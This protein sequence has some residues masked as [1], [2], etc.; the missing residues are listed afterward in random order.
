MV[1]CEKRMDQTKKRNPPKRQFISY[2]VPCLLL[3]EFSAVSVSSSTFSW[4]STILLL[5]KWKPIYYNIYTQMKE[6]WT[7]IVE[8]FMMG[9]KWYKN[10]F[11]QRKLLIVKSIHSGEWWWGIWHQKVSTLASYLND[12]L[13][14]ASSPRREICWS[15]NSLLTSL[16]KI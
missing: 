12:N 15:L 1:D 16:N 13:S 9:M 5:G 7:H 11:R 10:V 3:E 4:E 2:E 8:I 14:I 6:D